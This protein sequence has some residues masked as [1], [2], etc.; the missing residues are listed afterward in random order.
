M[1]SDLDLTDV[2]LAILGVLWER[3]EATVAQ[4]H[5]SLEPRM[6]ISQKTIGTLLLRL[7]QR[8][9]VRH[10]TVGRGNVY[11]AAV[12]RRTVLMARMAGLL[13]AVFDAGPGGASPHLVSDGD[14]RPGDVAYLRKL[15]RRAERDIQG[16]G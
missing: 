5:E 11:R 2:H 1:A 8:G 10:R 13:G 15:L 6:S 14:V 7:E 9:V 3:G 16:E 12:A 4:V